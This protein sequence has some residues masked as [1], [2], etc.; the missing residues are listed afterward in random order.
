MGT[1]TQL[2]ENHKYKSTL[3]FRSKSPAKA[4][5]P[6]PTAQ[7]NTKLLHALFMNEENK[8]DPYT[9]R[10]STSTPSISEPTSRRSSEGKSEAR[11]Q[12]GLHKMG[13]CMSSGRRREAY[14]PAPVRVVRHHHGGGGMGMGGYGRR[15][16]RMGGYGGGYGGGG[17]G[18]RRGR[19]C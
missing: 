6:R 9:R 2:Q 15:G 18:R 14:G 7:Q 8:R 1:Q 16:P 13:L 4:P 11:R 17:Y 10:P 19:R 5:S 12:D 3:M